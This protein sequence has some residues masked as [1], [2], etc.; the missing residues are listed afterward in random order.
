MQAR[1]SGRERLRV[2]S[3]I[4][5][6]EAHGRIEWIRVCHGI[7]S[8]RERKQCTCSE[9]VKVEPIQSEG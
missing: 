6:R 1:W 5:E 8:G 2:L 4:W 9:V 7:G 3:F